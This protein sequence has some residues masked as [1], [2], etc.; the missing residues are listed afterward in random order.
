MRVLDFKA[1]LISFVAIITYQIKVRIM[2][3][4]DFFFFFA[5]FLNNRAFLMMEVLGYLLSHPLLSV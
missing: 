5:Y 4:G 2:V 3:S 1:D